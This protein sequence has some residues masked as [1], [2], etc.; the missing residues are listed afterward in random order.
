MLERFIQKEEKFNPDGRERRRWQNGSADHQSSFI[1]SAQV[2][3]KRTSYTWHRA[4]QIP[5][6][7]HPW[8]QEVARTQPFFANPDRPRFFELHEGHLIAMEDCDTPYPKAGD[9]Y[10]IS[11]RIEWVVG[12]QWKT[13]FTPIEMVRV[14]TVVPELLGSQY[15]P[16]ENGDTSQD[17]LQRLSAGQGFTTGE[18][19]DSYCVHRRQVLTI[20]EQVP[21]ASSADHPRSRG[22]RL[23]TR[24]N[25][26]RKTL[27]AGTGT[28]CGS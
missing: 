21:R 10:W 24:F 19:F 5:F 27:A 20:F 17:Q 3:M 2:F 25:G 28:R 8:L 11:V 9:V 22:S 1:L 14:A 13:V 26:V 18:C 4:N 7:V 23:L 15:R 6:P 12:Q 16:D